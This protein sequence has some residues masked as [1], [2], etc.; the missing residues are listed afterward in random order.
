MRLVGP[1]SPELVVRDFDLGPQLKTRR[2]ARALELH[3]SLPSTNA[4]ALE[5]AKHGGAHGTAVLA[6]TQT[7]GRGQRGRTWFSPPGA[8][9]YVSFLLRPELPVRLASA[10]TLVA[11]VA[12]REALEEVAGVQAKLRW[13]NDLL[14]SGEDRVF[15]KLSGILME[16]SADQ[17][18]LEHAVLGIGINLTKTALPEAL[19]PAATSIEALTGDAPPPHKVLGAI[20]NHLEVRLE[21]MQAEGLAPAAAAWTDAALGLGETVEI[22]DG[23]RLV[24]GPLRGI[25]EDGALRIETADG[26]V[27]LYRGDLS[28]PGV[29][30]TPR[31]F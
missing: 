28:V 15:R 2:L 5:I 9:L 21:Q 19:T 24:R 13:P 8:G 26:V 6:L 27:N 14:A 23:T 4:R 10:L 31:T 20:S 25:A 3:E 30:K 1:D 29:P 11:G 17:I 12:V 22:D 7:Q 16:A 18:R